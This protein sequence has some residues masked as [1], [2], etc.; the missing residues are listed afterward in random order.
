MSDLVEQRQNKLNELKRLGDAYPQPNLASRQSTV[1]SL[2]ME[3]K[4]VTVAGRILLLRGHG[5]ILFADL[6]DLTGKIQLFFEKNTLADKMDQT[7]LF[8]LGDIISATG[9]VFKTTAGE[10]TIRV[11]D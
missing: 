7:K 6:H 1:E 11:S 10:T 2:K 8:D 3:G 9:I 4:Q 5:K